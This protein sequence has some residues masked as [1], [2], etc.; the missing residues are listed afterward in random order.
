MGGGAAGSVQV[1]HCVHAGG[2]NVRLQLSNCARAAEHAACASATMCVHE[3]C[4]HCVQA[5]ILVCGRDMLVRAQCAEWAHRMRAEATQA[6]PGPAVMLFGGAP[7]ECT[8]QRPIVVLWGEGGNTPGAE[9]YWC[10][11]KQPYLPCFVT[12]PS[13]YL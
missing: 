2:A 5:W 11:L 10:N 13:A 4:M 6:P 7:P 9:A 8:V 3:R 12:P 1:G